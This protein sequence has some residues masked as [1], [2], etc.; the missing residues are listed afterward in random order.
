MSVRHAA[1]R[2][3]A[4]RVVVVSVVTAA[5]LQTMS[6]GAVVAP[7]PA[8][9]RAEVAPDRP[10]VLIILTDD[11]RGGMSVMPN[12]RRH[13]GREGRRYP[14]AFATT[15]LCCPARASIMSGRFAHNHGVLHNGVLPSFD[16]SDMLQAVLKNQ[17]YHTGIFGKYLNGWSISQAPRNFDEFAIQQQGYRDVR[18]NVN[19]TVATLPDYA[20]HVVRDKAV[21]FIRSRAESPKPW[22]M[23]LMAFAPHSPWEPEAK[24]Q[25]A[26][27]PP[28]RANPAMRESDR[29]DKP[30]FVRSSNKTWQSHGQVAREGQFRMLMSVDDMV[31]AVMTELKRTGQEDT[32]AV[33]LSDNGRLWGEH[34][35]TKKGVPYTGAVKVPFYVRWPGR[36]APGTVDRR[37]SAN[38][39]I[40][41]TVLASLGLPTDT[42]DGRNL[43]DPSWSR[44]R[45]HLEYWCN[46]TH[47]NRWAS[48]RTQTYQFTRYYDDNGKVTFQEYYDLVNDPW[49]LNNIL[50]D[51]VRRNNPSRATMTAMK[52]TLWADRRCR[53]TD[54]DS[55]HPPACP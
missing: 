47:C 29:S 14:N 15:P 11:Q 37:L 16:D 52:K 21:E 48:T 55:D 34:G 8:P 42:R 35:W 51:G 32:I 28:A 18:W 13:F 20:T 38:I 2:V 5:L 39:D 45:M 33:F 31:S 44:D 10:N 26:Y 50:R 1:V 17:G 41:P 7:L 46:L 36:I 40:A 6:A 27:V 54:S 24:Y 43:L 49:Q 12:T 4:G 53:G 23:Y 25:D 9:A 3:R 19:G 22:L 30:P